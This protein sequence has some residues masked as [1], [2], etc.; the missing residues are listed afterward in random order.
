MIDGRI[1]AQFRSAYV[2]VIGLTAADVAAYVEGN[3]HRRGDLFEA[4]APPVRDL[5]L[6]AWHESSHGACPCRSAVVIAYG[7]GPG[8]KLRWSGI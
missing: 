5:L 2:Q 1:H 8:D 7:W 6:R 4:V 3:H